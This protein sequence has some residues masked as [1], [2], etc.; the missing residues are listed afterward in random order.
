MRILG[1]AAFT[2]VGR[3]LGRDLAG[4]LEDS[5]QIS[6]Y[7]SDLKDWC[8]ARF[9][10]ASAILF[11]SACGIAVRTIAPFLQ[12][13]TKDPAVLV[14]D[15]QAHHVIS[16]VSGH[17]GGANE[18]AEEIGARTGAVPVITTASDVRGKIA[19]DVF[20]KKNGLV[21]ANMKDA[22]KIEA[23]I[24]RGEMVGVYCEG[25]VEG[26]CPPELVM[27]EKKESTDKRLFAGKAE[28]KIMD[29]ASAKECD[30]AKS[31]IALQENGKGNETEP[32]GNL[33]WISERTVP[34]PES[35]EWPHQVVK[36][37]QVLHLIPR[38]VVLGVGCRR[39]KEK[40]A[41]EAVVTRV[42]AESGISREALCGA[43]S[44][45][46]KKE[47][48]GILDLCSEWDLPYTV[49]SA[50]ELQRVEGN[51]TPSSFVAKTTG[52]DNV[53]ER[54]A[55][56]LAGAGSHLI[57]RKQA[58]NGVTAALAVKEWRIKFEK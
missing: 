28:Q 24:L 38:N 37:A 26:S 23:A 10:D 15:E 34:S 8:R 36:D 54:S 50:E 12:S 35:S 52:V 30:M 39:G 9:A 25:A 53:C 40:E 6:W 32:M 58:E 55:L 48:A 20:A 51:F 16:L 57:H 49:F 31:G 17:I 18:L 5:W 27:L 1:I 29:T 22:K 56:A 46:L 47:E 13:K 44:I 33:I 4:Q 11:I 43:A 3:A 21:I 41:I 2:E 42:I 14:M 7:E 19:V 45:D